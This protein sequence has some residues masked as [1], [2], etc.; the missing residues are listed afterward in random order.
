MP[1]CE[2]DALPPLQRSMPTVAIFGWRFLGRCGRPIFQ[3]GFGSDAG[4]ILWRWVAPRLGS[5]LARPLW[6]PSR[7]RARPRFS[8]VA[9]PLPFPRARQ[10]SQLRSATSSAIPLLL[11]AGPRAKPTGR[12]SSRLPISRPF[13]PRSLPGSQRGAWPPVSPPFLL[14]FLPRVWP[15]SQLQPSPV[16]GLGSL[17]R[18][19]TFSVHFPSRILLPSIPAPDVRGVPWQSPSRFLLRLCCVSVCPLF[20]L[21]RRRHRPII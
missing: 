2:N 11:P 3:L 7:P 10:R 16:I 1:G 4:P 8:T 18:F 20:L 9:V 13:L 17:P 19:S 21:F 15:S 5:E 14:R 6:L 12:L